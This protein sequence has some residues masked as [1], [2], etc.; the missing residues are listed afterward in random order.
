[1]NAE[2]REALEASIL[3]WEENLTA[4]TPSEVTLGGE[5]CALCLMFVL[6]TGFCRGC[7][8]REETGNTGCFGTPY[9]RAVL[10]L[11]GWKTYKT[12][13]DKSRWQEYAKEE[14]EFLKGLRDETN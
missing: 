11:N 10:A 3:H 7:P 12:E 6:D 1:M 14:L 5:S 4:E 8:V 9:H 2:T 13:K